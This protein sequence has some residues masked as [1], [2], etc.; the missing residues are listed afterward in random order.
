[1]PLS[2]SNIGY[3]RKPLPPI[4]SGIPIPTPAEQKAEIEAQGDPVWKYS[5]TQSQSTAD[6]VSFHS[7]WS[8]PSK[9]K[10]FPRATAAVDFTC[11]RNGGVMFKFEHHRLEHWIKL[12]DINSVS[13]TVFENELGKQLAP[14][15]DII[16][17]MLDLGNLSTEATSVRKGDDAVLDMIE[18]SKLKNV[19]IQHS[20]LGIPSKRIP[21]IIAAKLRVS[22]NIKG[23]ALLAGE[24]LGDEAEQE[25]EKEE[26]EAKLRALDKI[27]PPNS[28][29]AHQLLYRQGM[30]QFLQEITEEEPVRIAYLNAQKA[31][32][33]MFAVGVELPIR[34]TSG[35]IIAEFEKIV[36]PMDNENKN[37]DREEETRESMPN[38]AHELKTNDSVDSVNSGQS[39]E[40]LLSKKSKRIEMKRRS[41]SVTGS[42]SKSETS[43]VE[44]I[45]QDDGDNGE[46]KEPDVENIPE[47]LTES[48]KATLESPDV[49][50]ETS[51]T[52]QDL[53]RNAEVQE[54][55]EE[56]E[57]RERTATQVSSH[58]PLARTASAPKLSK[59]RT[60][61]SLQ[62]AKSHSLQSLK[63]ISV[64]DLSGASPRPS[65]GILKN[66][67]RPSSGIQKSISFAD[68]VDILNRSKSA[69]SSLSRGNH[70]K[71][72]SKSSSLKN[73][74]SAAK[75]WS[76]PSKPA[77]AGLI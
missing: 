55:H 9:F 3:I 11:S 35:E 43:S 14:A 16:N 62:S 72:I 21:D 2:Q 77:T 1:M 59:S 44:A 63:S 5:T 54:L 41:S 17:K 26:T 4:D 67:S 32:N 34:K 36:I 22:D 30:D 49:P 73:L 61:I 40:S 60:N 38:L 51:N 76:V 37:E 70:S 33:E 13:E 6:N 23:G 52:N 7:V 27:I 45:K 42:F 28:Y 53:L 29:T 39:K 74:S 12:P 31:L 25:K 75:P 58:T 8:E 18:L 56:V 64:Q 65:S 46:V 24:R 47:E 68:E 66:S 71:P 10:P 69:R 19:G 50:L 20:T 57:I 15:P 48:P